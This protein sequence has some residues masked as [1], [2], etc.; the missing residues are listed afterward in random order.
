MSET[1]PIGWIKVDLDNVVIYGKGKK[2]KMLSKSCRQGMVPYINIKAFEQGIIDE[3]A[4]VLSSKLIEENDI[5]VVWDG[6]RFGLTGT[7]MKG[8]AG[9]TLMVLTPVINNPK[10]IYNFIN[11]YYTYINTKPKGAATPHVDPDIFWK[12]QFPI[13]PLNEQKRIVAKLD[14]IISRIDAIKE[15]L[16]KLPVIIKRF[17]QSVLTA[18][19]TGKLTE[20]WREEHLDVESAAVLLERI[21]KFRHENT[22]NKRE[23]NAVK[24]N[25]LEGDK[26]LKSK[27]KHFEIPDNWSFCE[28]N[29]IGNVYN[30]STPSR[31][32]KEYW[33]GDIHWVSSG[34][35]AN[36]IIISTKETITKSGYDNSSVKLFPKG[37]VLIAMIGEGKTRGQVA[38]LN[39][40]STCNQNVAAV[41]INHGFVLSKYLFLWFLMQYERNRSFGSGS[42][43]KALNCQRVR[44]L[45]FVLPP[46]EEQKEIVR[47]VD[48][49]FAVSDKLEKHYQNA[50]AKVD[51]LAQSVLA[52]AFRGEL[53]IT[54]AELAEKEGRNFESAEKLLERIQVEKAKMEAELKMLKRTKRKRL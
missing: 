11:R 8:A 21:K 40:V 34:E 27:K 52:K 26:R 28:I 3:Y 13:A 10:Y 37:T 24:K 41:L 7:G 22:K 16:D 14:K 30:G 38:I 54:E 29:S 51:K 15:R 43:P 5:L 33:N 32:V 42:G 47:Q 18:A 50:K 36:S 23:L 48:K 6:A 53:V 12:L 25:Y 44:E 49:L 45:D 19:V 20:K 1:L 2:P 31:K 4:E 17:R 39:I 9:S 46:L 35:V